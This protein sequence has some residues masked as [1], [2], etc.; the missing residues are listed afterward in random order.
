VEAVDRERF[1]IMVGTFLRAALLR[2]AGEAQALAHRCCAL[3]SRAAGSARPN[4]HRGRLRRMCQFAIKASIA[5]QDVGAH[6]ARSQWNTGA[7]ESTVFIERKA[8]S[9]H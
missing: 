1:A 8:G 3:R 2:S 7:F 5:E 4:S 6:R 9:A